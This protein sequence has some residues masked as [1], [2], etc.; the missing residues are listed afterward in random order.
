MKIYY[1]LG[2]HRALKLTKERAFDNEAIEL[3]FD[4]PAM[5]RKHQ[6]KLIA[7]TAEKR[8]TVDL[9]ENIAVLPDSLVVP[10]TIE[11][12]LVGA[13]KGEELSI[14]CDSLTIESLA[15]FAADFE[16]VFPA[17]VALPVEVKRLEAELIKQTE[18]LNALIA[19]VEA[20]QVI[21]QSIFI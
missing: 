10:Q 18:R 4:I 9:V 19:I 20:K 6:F 14:K 11:L 8:I 3:I 12:T 2:E 17:Y 16:R 13:H 7:Q 5:F 21:K 15:D 1:R